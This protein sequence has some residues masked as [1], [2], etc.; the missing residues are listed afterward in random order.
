M[1]IAASLHHSACP[2]DCPSTCALVVE[3][4]AE[5]YREA[6]FRITGVRLPVVGVVMGSQSDC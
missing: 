1:G 3:R 5:K 4:T 2:H 6:L